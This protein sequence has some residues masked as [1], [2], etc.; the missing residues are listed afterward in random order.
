MFGQANRIWKRPLPFHIAASN[1]RERFNSWMRNEAE[2]ESIP[3]AE[4]R[5]SLAAGCAKVHPILRLISHLTLLRLG[6][7]TPTLFNQSVIA[8]IV[9]G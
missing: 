6:L 3:L 8:N 5:Y 4:L 9:A 2:V 7:A 1:F